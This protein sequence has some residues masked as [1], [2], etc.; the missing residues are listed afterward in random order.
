M[1]YTLTLSDSADED[2]RKTIVQTLVRYNEGVAGPSQHRALVVA[3]RDEVGAVMGGLWGATAHG[4]L[5]TQMLSV[6][7]G[8]Q[9]QGVGRALMAQAEKEAQARGCRNAWVDTQFGARGFYEKLGY[10]CF[11]EL[12]DYPPGFSRVFLQKALSTS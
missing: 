12:G 3:I 5:Y 2:I 9:G 7:L 4:W 10:T 6:P 8:L 1:H 11:G